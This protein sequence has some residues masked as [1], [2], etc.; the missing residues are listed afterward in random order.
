[1]DSLSKHKETCG[2]SWYPEC[3]DG[4]PHCSCKEAD[5][6]RSLI[7]ANKAKDLLE[8]LPEYSKGS[9]GYKRKAALGRAV[10]E[11]EAGNG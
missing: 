9:S 4:C 2:C 3:P 10:K 6:A 1:M 11:W 5:Y 7:L 8:W